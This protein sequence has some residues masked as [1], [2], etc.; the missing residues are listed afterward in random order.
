MVAFH[1][2]AEVVVSS[3]SPSSP[4][5]GYLLSSLLLNLQ[6]HQPALTALQGFLG[7][8]SFSLAP[9]DESQVYF[10]DTTNSR[11]RSLYT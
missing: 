6:K 3:R 4:S 9:R 2:R 10:S 11:T 7:C 8:T 1:L 5:F